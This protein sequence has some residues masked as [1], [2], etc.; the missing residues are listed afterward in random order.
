MKSF[1]ILLAVLAIWTIGAGT[2]LAAGENGI[3]P[4]SAVRSW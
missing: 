4:C 2:T 1:A 3:R